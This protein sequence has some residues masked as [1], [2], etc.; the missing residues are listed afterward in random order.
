MP[1]SS[2]SV[3][4]KLP[5]SGGTEDVLVVGNNL[6][7]T[8]GRV[9]HGNVVYGNYAEVT[10]YVA[11]IMEGTLRKDTVIDFQAAAAHLLSLSSQFAAYGVNGSAGLQFGKLALHG[12]D[13]SLNVFKIW[14]DTLGMANDFEINVPNGSSVLVNIFGSYAEWK[15][16]LNVYGT[17]YSNVLYNFVEADSIKI[18]NIDVRGSILAPRTN[19][20]FVSGVQN[21]QMVAKNAK[22]IGQY[23]LIL[24]RG[25][26]PVDT[27]VVNVAEVVAAVQHDPDSS[28]NNHL[29]TEDDIASA[30]IIIDRE[31]NSTSGTNYNWQQI[32]TV[33]LIR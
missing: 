22:G 31:I 33:G 2:Y 6:Y 3:G 10:P 12:S 5:N 19:V 11:S 17:P 13:P 8:S 21:G 14:G 32:S 23:N 1:H 18:S 24:F 28:P 9:F 20:N 30:S 7:F 26:I 15:G 16:G 27:T 29:A 25:N 4:D